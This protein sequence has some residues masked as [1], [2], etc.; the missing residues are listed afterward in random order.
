MRGQQM[1]RKHLLLKV[2]CIVSPT[3]IGSAAQAGEWSAVSY[4]K[5]TGNIGYVYRSQD[6]GSARKVA[7]AA[8]RFGVVK[9]EGQTKKFAESCCD[10]VQVSNSECYTIATSI[11]SRKSVFVARHRD[12]T[13]AVTSSMQKCMKK[14]RF[15]R[16]LVIACPGS[17]R[18]G[19]EPDA[20]MGWGVSRAFPTSELR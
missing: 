18:G 8:C 19:K 13:K 15:C 11:D 6:E 20:A 5:K 2:L 17:K 14:G 9:R 16:M 7:N 3:F 4:C 10:V 12:K 1:M